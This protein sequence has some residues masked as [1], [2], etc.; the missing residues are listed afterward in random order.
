MNFQEQI[1]SPLWQ[2]KRLEILERD[3]FTCRNCECKDK[4][5]HIHHLY[6]I[7]NRM[8]WNYNNTSLITVCEDCHKKMPYLQ[9]W[10]LEMLFGVNKDYDI[11][12]TEI[13]DLIALKSKNKDKYDVF[14]K[15]IDIYN[16]CDS[17][18]YDNE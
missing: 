6:Y 14:E 10:V 11:I 13:V 3:E 8:I 1:K 18:I 15:C 17:K 16:C 5:L 7:K 9:R 2:K 12:L 4:T